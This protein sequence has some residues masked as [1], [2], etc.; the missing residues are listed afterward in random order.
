[1]KTI[2]IVTHLHYTP[3]QHAKLAGIGEF[4]EHNVNKISEEEL[5]SLVTD[6][7]YIILGASGVQ[8]FGEIAFQSAKN[9]K[10]ISVLGSGVDFIDL[11]AAKAHNVV[12]SNARGANAQ[13]VAEHAFG[14][15]LSLSKRITE[16][17]IGLKDHDASFTQFE[18]IELSGK[19][20]GIIG[21]GEIGSR[22]GR[23]AK[24][25]EMEVYF[26]QRT[27][28]VGLDGEYEQ[29]DL[30]R[31]LEISD[32]IVVTVPGN[33][34]AEGMISSEQFAKMK[35]GAIL[36]S[37]SRESVIDK[38]ATLQALDS[39]KLFGFGFDADISTLPDPVYY[40]YPN[41]LI[42]PHTAFITVES[43][44]KVINTAIEN[45]LKFHEGEIQ[46]R[47]N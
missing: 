15:V 23:I 38:N 6:A 1:M 7:D 17:H 16:S 35:K 2:S 29:V 21:F 3:D 9:L 27:K 24:G 14:M 11:D 10:T 19:N 13:S 43:G 41:V 39:E 40:K 33:P 36:V 18:G 5:A 31:L 44:I 47:V 37:I 26:H 46:N 30:D 4:V 12:V 20:I 22:V 28:A 32:V 25:F 45:I 42:T 34:T 8:H